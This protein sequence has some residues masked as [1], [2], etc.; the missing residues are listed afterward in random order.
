MQFM[1]DT[2]ICI[3][4]TNE[5]PPS[6]L[7]A[8]RD[9]HAEGLGI[10]T[11]TACELHFGVARTGSARNAKALQL[12]LAGLEVANLDAKA[13]D[14]AGRVR[15]WLASRGTRIGSHD[16]LIAAHAQALGVTLLTHNTREFEPVPGLKVENWAA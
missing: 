2:D 7:R 16:C 14:D 12:S 3:Q 5:R 1:L 10:S 11:I 15:A 13:A 8:L 4:V 9:H 6:M